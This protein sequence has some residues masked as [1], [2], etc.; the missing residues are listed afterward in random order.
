M[1]QDTE[2]YDWLCF[3]LRRTN[4]LHAETNEVL[5]RIK[6]TISSDWHQTAMIGTTTSCAHSCAQGTLP[7]NHITGAYPLR[8]DCFHV[9]E[10]TSARA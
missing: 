9:T 8:P 10:S 2:S 6:L 3:I 1:C 7:C 5:V 4:Y